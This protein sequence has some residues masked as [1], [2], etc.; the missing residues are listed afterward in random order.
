LHNGHWKHL[1][2][3][4]AAVIPG[5]QDNLARQASGADQV[6]GAINT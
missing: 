1:L 2:L 5:A 4:A 6:G 3:D